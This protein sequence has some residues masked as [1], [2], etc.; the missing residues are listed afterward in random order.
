VATQRQIALNPYFWITVLAVLA[1]DQLVKWVLVSRLALG[2]SF[3][4]W[5]RWLSLTLQTNRGAVFG[6]WAEGHRWLLP[7]GLVLVLALL[8]WGLRLAGPRPRA[9][10]PLGLILGGA[11]GNLVD[12]VVHHYVIDYLDLHFW[13]VFNLA[14]IAITVGVVFFASTSCARPRPI[15]LFPPRKDRRKS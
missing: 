15:R 2:E 13:P 4:I 3:P 14:D 1:A 12:R 8:W 10:V 9:L 6:L 11:L 7:L 5:G